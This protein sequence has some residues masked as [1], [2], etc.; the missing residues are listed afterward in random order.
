[1]GKDGQA[2]IGSS[3]KKSSNFMSFVECIKLF[4]L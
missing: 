2:M 3:S 1:M 4:K